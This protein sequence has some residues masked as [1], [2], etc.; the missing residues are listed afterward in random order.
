VATEQLRDLG[1]VAEVLVPRAIATFRLTD[2]QTTRSGI[3]A[4]ACRAVDAGKEP[5][6]LFTKLVKGRAWECSGVHGL[7][8]K[9]FDQVRDWQRQCQQ[10]PREAAPPDRYLAAL[11]ADQDFERQRAQHIARLQQEF[12]GGVR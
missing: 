8:E 4:C 3:L 9:Y 10:L 12:R 2:S 11:S 7:A 1:T 6:K 5:P